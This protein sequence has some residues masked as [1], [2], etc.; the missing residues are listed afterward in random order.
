MAL[1]PLH[2]SK[3]R[4]ADSAHAAIMAALREGSLKPGDR[5]VMDRIAAELG[6]SRTPVRDA[7]QR[8]E[9]EGVIVASPP[10]G[11]EVRTVSAAEIRAIYQAREAVEGYAARVVA[12]LGAEAVAEVEQA[13]DAAAEMDA[14]TVHG[15]FAANVAVHRGIVSAAGNSYL[16]DLFDDVWGRVAAVLSFA[17]LYFQEIEHPDVRA[18]H[19]K[20]V[21]AL[22]SGDAAK[23]ERAAINHIRDGL[24]R[25]LPAG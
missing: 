12:G 19:A 4:L 16:V 6:I 5:L 9:R 23:A 3:N 21:R 17:E 2:Q 24:Q 7:L 14:S 10:R 22:R 8:L 1:Q 11:Y 18:D 20:L 13:M 15:A 25:N